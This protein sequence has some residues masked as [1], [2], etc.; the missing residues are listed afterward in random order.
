[1]QQQEIVAMK[2]RAHSSPMKAF[3]KSSMAKAMPKKAKRGYKK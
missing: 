1:M 2:Y 3:Q